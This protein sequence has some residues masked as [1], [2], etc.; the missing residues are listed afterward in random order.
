M[1]KFLLFTTLLALGSVLAVSGCSTKPG[2]TTTTAPPPTTTLPAGE[3]PV[4][5]VSVSGPY[6]VY[7]DGKPLWN[8]GGPVV[9]ITLK[10]VSAEPV[11]S[12]TA[13]L[14]IER[15]GPPGLSSFV[16]TFDVTSA[17]PLLPGSDISVR[18]T[19]IGGGFSDNINYLL[20]INGTLQSGA[21]FAY[22]KQVL[23]TAPAQ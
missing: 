12:L 2:T 13:D 16:F 21:G 1:N 23:I 9:E 6:P 7:V 20:T 18:Q 19:L 14:G 3:E 22:T 17:A 10:N 4:A 5:L 15:A 11:A 8:P